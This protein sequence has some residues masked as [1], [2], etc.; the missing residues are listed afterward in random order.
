MS[1]DEW[2]KVSI[3]ETL[4]DESVFYTRVRPEMRLAEG[5]TARK[6]GQLPKTRVSNGRRPISPPMWPVT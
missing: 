4:L 2:M 1:L 6:T 5:C 3:D